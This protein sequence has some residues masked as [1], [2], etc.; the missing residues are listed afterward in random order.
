MPGPTD[1]IRQNV[2]IATPVYD[3]LMSKA[4]KVKLNG[5][6]PASTNIAGVIKVGQGG[7]VDFTTVADAIADAVSRGASF[8]NRYIIQIYPGIYVE[9]PM[10]IGAGI[11]LQGADNTAASAFVFAADPSEDLI[12]V[13]GSGIEQGEIYGLFLRG[14][15]APTKALIRCVSGAGNV[16]NCVLNGCSNGIWIESGAGC[17]VN[18][19]LFPVF[20]PGDEIDRAVYVAP[21]AGL[22]GQDCGLLGGNLLFATPNS[23]LIPFIFSRNPIQICLNSE[24]GTILN[25]TEVHVGYFDNTQ[26]SVLVNYTQGVFLF[27][28]LFQENYCALR[29]GAA[30]PNAACAPAALISTAPGASGLSCICAI[31]ARFS[32]SSTMRLSS[33]CGMLMTIQ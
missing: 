8:F 31:S 17:I 14:V 22:V 27:Q 25:N 16:R 1:L 28:S 13:T 3:G 29:I 23:A 26:V 18:D 24:G 20:F 33:P 30:A 6:G 32:P 5:L 19:L 2:G 15:T 11:I 21:G 10:A 7:D 4:D 12:T 9:P